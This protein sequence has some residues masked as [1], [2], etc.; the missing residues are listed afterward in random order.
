[1]WH[2]FLCMI[3]DD[4]PAGTDKCSHLS[5]HMG[6]VFHRNAQ[7]PVD[8]SKGNG[9]QPVNGQGIEDALRQNSDTEV[10]FDHEQDA[11]ILVHNG[12]AAQGKTGVSEGFTH[13]VIESFW[14]DDEFLLGQ[15]Q[16]IEP[17]A[18]RQGVSF[19]H[20]DQHPVFDQRPYHQAFMR[21]NGD[22][23]ALYPFLQ[24]RLFHSGIV[25]VYH[26]HICVGAELVETV[27]DRRQ[28]VEGDAVEGADAQGAAAP[29]FQVIDLLRQHF[30][31]CSDFF[32]IGQEH[33]AFVGQLHAVLGADEQVDAP[34]LFQRFQ[35][36]ADTGLGVAQML[37]GFGD[38]F[39]LG[40]GDKCG[41][42]AVQDTCLLVITV[43][44]TP[45]EKASL[46][47]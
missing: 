7:C 34:F 30:L 13:G 29:A 11:V 22:E 35:L 12:F 1:M 44:N 28:P 37:G 32:D 3:T 42:L 24:Q 2:D 43:W 4:I 23:A 46:F 25:A 17:G 16:W 20:D 9:H 47:R 39:Q 26:G 40:G 45:L 41:I 27:Q 38:A 36:L 15:I 10:L 18:G 14:R 19:R 6:G 33:A 8:I 5:G 31:V 21:G